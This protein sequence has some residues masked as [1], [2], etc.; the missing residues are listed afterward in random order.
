MLNIIWLGMLLLSVVVGIIQ[1]RIPEVVQAITDSAK[2]GF[3]L[4]LGLAGIMALWLGILAIASESGLVTLFARGLK[5]FLKRLFPDV[6]VEHPA[7]S[8]ILMN[9]AAN[10]L[11]VA[12]AATPFGL[13]AMEELQAL[14]PDKE[15]ASDSMCVFL[16]INTSS[17]QLI[18]ATAIAFLAANGSTNPGS[19]IFTTLIATSISTAVAIIA[20]KTFARMS[21]FKFKAVD[22]V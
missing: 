22:P 7:M 4:A 14:N 10:M 15:V 6:P 5:P 16:A 18:P 11:G 1:G 9:I 2:F 12:N 21:F 8:S 20:V 13:K 17:V 19:V 3:E